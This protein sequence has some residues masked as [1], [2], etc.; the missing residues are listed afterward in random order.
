MAFSETRFLVSNHYWRKCNKCSIM[1][2]KCRI[3]ATLRATVSIFSEMKQFIKL[4]EIPSNGVNRCI[5]IAPN[6]L[7]ILQ[8]NNVKNVSATNTKYSI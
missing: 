8:I 2:S 6:D 4:K 1:R 3:F 5:E 7:L